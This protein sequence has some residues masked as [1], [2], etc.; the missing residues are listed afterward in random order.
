MSIEGFVVSAKKQLNELYKQRETLTGVEKG[1]VT[2]KINDIKKTI[3]R[4]T[5]KGVEE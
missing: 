1:K 2:A 3:H 4:A 5:R